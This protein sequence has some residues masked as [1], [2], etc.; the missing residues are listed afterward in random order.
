MRRLDTIIALA[1]VAL[2]SLM[3]ACAAAGGDDGGA[4]NLP[5][6]GIAGWEPTS[7]DPVLSSPSTPAE[8]GGPTIVTTG[9]RV[10]VWFHQRTELGFEVRRA[11]AAHP[12]A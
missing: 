10:F 9:D 2:P 5:G 1:S 7:E 12:G 3:S 11:E 4:A 6:R 8:V